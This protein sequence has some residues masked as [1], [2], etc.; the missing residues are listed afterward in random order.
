MSTAR[1]SFAALRGIE[2][3]SLEELV[4]AS[5][6]LSLVPGDVLFSQGDAADALY[7][8]LEG[9][10]EVSLD[11]P[12][13]ARRVLARLGAGEC[14]G[15]MAVLTGAP[16]AATV[17]VV[18]PARV[19]R[20]PL[21]VCRRVMDGSTGAR[22]ALSKL[23]SRRLPSLHLGSAELFRDV[24]PAVLRAFDKE[25]NWIRLRGGE[26]L[27]HQGDAADAVYVVV[28]GS[29]EVLVEEPG[30]AS[31]AVDVLG[32]GAC[33]GEMAALGGEPRSA[34]LRAIRDSELACVSSSEFTGLLDAHP[35]FAANIARLL[36][37]RLKQTTSLSGGPR[38]TRT[39]VLLPT[40]AEGLLPA[41]TA[42]LMDALRAVGGSATLLTSERAE[43]ELGLGGA[44]GAAEDLADERV[45]GWL[46]EQESKFRYVVYACDPT[47]SLWTR[48]A[49]RQADRVMVV[50]HGGA[51]STPG[52]LEAALATEPGRAE[53][54]ELVLVHPTDAGDPS[55]TARWLA[56][57]RLRGHH[58][59]RLGRP[60]DF[61]RLARSITGTSIGVVLS[62]GGA[63][64][65]AHIGMLQ[66]I[67]DQGLA[68]DMIGG[69]SMGSVIAAQYAMGLDT[70][71]MTAL[72]RKEFLGCAVIGDL[73]VPMV[74]LMK[75]HSTVK[76][77]RAMFGDLQI[78]DLPM[79]YFCVSC[80]LSR[81][82]VV[83]HEHGPLWLWTRAS[84]SVPGIGPPVP[85]E[86]DL[87]VDGG[88]LNNLPAD[89]MA[90]RCAG[91]VF[92]LDVSAAVELHTEAE[93][94]SEMS[95]WPHLFRALNP[96]TKRPAFPSMLRLLARTATLSSVQNTEFMKQQADLYLHPP[97]D[98]I[99]PLDWGSIER[100]V[101]IGYRYAMDRVQA[102][103]LA[104][105][106]VPEPRGKLGGHA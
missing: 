43:R 6:E 30:R 47:L 55:G 75:G 10:V 18:E 80:N 68:V 72:N 54:P 70:A 90:K 49:L 52:E 84:C 78:E 39:V 81:A 97:T 19:V 105:P 41:F 59:V 17:S 46:G 86:G 37:R 57:R 67:H 38:S 60:G 76:L 89:I 12:G 3:S 14:V 11:A 23:T 71:T 101:E 69:T 61:E 26:V 56:G 25:A 63:R 94:Q 32:R 20:V 31:R 79:P 58:H 2:E 62:G 5:A 91:P 96:F 93:L 44:H 53:L 83:V 73:T 34:T 22:A 85:Y 13:R 66:A 77:L 92:A 27:F 48:C 36:A 98:A 8:I 21:D 29:L 106:G 33:I 40:R 100:V 104:R 51:D 45:L 50:G 16:R 64:G 95:G 7:L 103:R 65:F 35:R 74:A 42:S 28:H 9:A 87:L 1:T 88:V 82:E 15:E 4:R 24:D 99:D 102:W